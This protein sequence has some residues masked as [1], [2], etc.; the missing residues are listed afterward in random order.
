[1]RVSIAWLM[2]SI[3]AAI[4]SGVGADFVSNVQFHPVARGPVGDGQASRAELC[5]RVDR[6]PV[7]DGRLDEACWR[8]ATPLGEFLLYGPEEVV[9]R[10]DRTEVRLLFDAEALYVGVRCFQAERIDLGQFQ[11]A[12]KDYVAAKPVSNADDRRVWL[13]E[14]LEIFVDANLDRQSYHQFAVNAAGARIDYQFGGQNLGEKWHSANTRFA[15]TVTE[16]CWTAEGRIP[17]PDLGLAVVPSGH[18]VGFNV[19]RNMKAGQLLV[20]SGYT[21]KGRILMSSLTGVYGKP[22]RFMAMELGRPD[23]VIRALE[24]GAVGPGDNVAR[25]TVANLSGRPMQLRGR[26]ALSGTVETEATTPPF[27]LKAGAEREVRLAFRIDPA[28]PISLLTF[29]VLGR[30]GVAAS[31]QRQPPKLRFFIDKERYWGSDCKGIAA[32]YFLSSDPGKVPKGLTWRLHLDGRQVHAGDMRQESVGFHFDLRKVAP[33]EHTLEFAA[34][35]ATGRA[36]GQVVRTFRKEPASDAERPVDRQ[37]LPL[38]FVCTGGSDRAALPLTFGVPFPRGVLWSSEHIRVVAKGA[39]EIPSQ[40]EVTQR[41]SPEGAIRWALVTFQ[42][43]LDSDGKARKPYAIEFGS[44]VR[45]RD[46]PSPL[47]VHQDSERISV[48]TGPL[49]FAVRKKTFG[50]IEDVRIGEEKVAG[51]RLGGSYFVDHEG[52]AYYSAL[53]SDAQVTVEV[54]GPERVVIRAEGWH[55]SQDGERL[56]KHITRIWAFRGKPYLRVFH[57]LIITSDSRKVRCR[58]LGLRIP[59]ARPA[60]AASFWQDGKRVDVPVSDAGS[61]SLLQ[62]GWD[63][64]TVNGARKTHAEGKQADGLFCTDRVAIA[65]REPWQNYPKELEVTPEAAIIHFWPAHNTASRHKPEDVTLA[66]VPKLW[67]CHEGEV[68]DLQTPA[69]Y[70]ERFPAKASP[71]NRNS[72]FVGAIRNANAMGLAKTHEFW[73]TFAPPASPAELTA[74]NRAVQGENNAHA[75]LHWICSSAAATPWPIHPYDPQRFPQTERFLRA[76]FDFEDRACEHTQDYG[77]WNLGDRHTLW[78]SHEKRWSNWRVWRGYHHCSARWPWIGYLRTGAPKYLTF[79]RRNALHLV[80]VD[81]CNYAAPPFDTLGYPRGKRLYGQNDYKGYVHWHGGHFFFC[82]NTMVDFGFYLYHVTG[83]RRGYDVVMGRLAQ[84]RDVY[85]RS[86]GLGRQLAH[87]ISAMTFGLQETFDPLLLRPLQEHVQKLVDSQDKETGTYL[88]SAGA[89]A[90]PWIPRYVSYAGSGEVI[91]SLMLVMKRV[92]EHPAPNRLYDY[93]TTATRVTGD[94]RYVRAGLSALQHAIQSTYYKE[95]DL[96]DG[97]YQS[98]NSV[99]IPR[100]GFNVPQL[101]ATLAPLG[102][103]TAAPLDRIKEKLVWTGTPTSKAAL[104]VLDEQDQQLDLQ[105]TGTFRVRDPKQWPAKPIQY[106]LIGPDGNRAAGGDVPVEPKKTEF[107]FT[108]TIPK[109]GRRGVYALELALAQGASLLIVQ[110]PVPGAPRQVYQCAG[111]LVRFCWPTERNVY[112]HVPSGCKQVDVRVTLVPCSTAAIVS[113][114][115]AV[116]AQ[117]EAEPDKSVSYPYVACKVDAAQAGRTWCL[118]L[119]G[120]FHTKWPN[121]QFRSPLPARV[122]L[123][124]EAM[125]A[126]PLP[127]PRTD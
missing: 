33:G 73:I 123:T 75:P 45:R 95:G 36:L 55:A 25:M 61:A 62:D 86:E 103:E 84:M 85:R 72:N 104:L 66:D 122:T 119:R 117:A 64:V 109:D 20:Y 125:F 53:A 38:S 9:P 40:I 12:L 112:F 23:V 78:L 16:D 99:G 77:M 115:G 24:L 7:I 126:D 105:L 111:G 94:D 90:Y 34:L 69:W 89:E 48:D 32:G 47:T 6:P 74:F 101:M 21:S 28:Q 31:E 3:V 107:D 96:H 27:E 51:G 108:L 87:P 81:T 13:G 56:G 110:F 120:N 1:M 83:V 127:A 15:A 46:F 29:S 18:R 67:F 116:A 50:F 54:A 114:D 8:Q 79:G 98:A 26:V 102:A 39:K 63:H 42:P 60:T 14:A 41:W 43:E 91:A 4:G 44:A 30:D 58:D 71:E 76:I 121:F 106:L 97:L 88:Y 57:T 68:L 118:R 10:A 65:L 80:D 49:R 35:D 52:R 2:A 22:E 124:P 82:H 5:D 100:A 37:L 70:A 19:A 11:S 17:F 93:Y 92:L 59:L 113:P